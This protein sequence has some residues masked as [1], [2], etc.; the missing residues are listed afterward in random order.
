MRRGGARSGPALRHAKSAKR[1]SVE[2]LEDRALLSVNLLHSFAGGLDDGSVPYGNL[3]SDGSA[4]YGTT[5]TGGSSSAGTA[6]SINADGTNYQVLH[7]F[8]AGDGGGTPMAGLTLVGNTLFG[9]ASVGG[10]ANRFGVLFS[11]STNGSNFQVLHAFAGQTVLQGTDGAT[12]QAG[13]IVVG[14]TLYGTTTAGGSGGSGE[15]TAFSI[16]T[17]GSNYQVIHSFTGG[18]SDGIAPD[19]ELTVVGSVLYGTTTMGGTANDGTVF[20]MNLDGSNFHVVH[21]FSGGTTD[22]S[23]P[24]AG[25]FAIGTTLYG[26]TLAGGNGTGTVFAVNTDGSNFHLLHAFFFTNDGNGLN[27]AADLTLVDTVLYGTTTSGGSLNVGT[28]FTINPDGSNFQTVYSFKGGQADGSDPRS[29]LTLIG[30]NLFGTTLASGN[31]GDGTVFSL[32]AGPATYPAFITALYTDVLGRVPDAVGAAFYASQLSIGVPRSTVV[33]EFWQ[34]R[35]HRA[36]EVRSYYQ[37]ILHRAA[38]SGGLTAWTNAMVAGATEEAV[39]TAFFNSAEFQADNPTATAFVDALYADLL[40]RN[41][42]SGGESYWVTALTNSAL[43]RLQVIQS[44]VGSQEYHLLLVDGYYQAFLGRAR[45]C[46]R[47]VL[48]AK[49]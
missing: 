48:G 46:W 11:M 43:T 28:V 39:I 14:S 24:E 45:R 12:P 38:D 41:A 37:S 1:L 5:S 31:S 25:L 27:P 4:L 34:S 18:T 13:L 44:F 19:A 6:F 17:D 33:A 40:G 26:T 23:D 8:D 47:D 20:A 42:D 36:I 3:A 7:S 29:G 16:H 21:S 2:Q 15:G 22:G 32:A 30:S 10:G 35:E 49:T 9:T